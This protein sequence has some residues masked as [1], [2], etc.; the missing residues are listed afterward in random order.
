MELDLIKLIVAAVYLYL[1]ITLFMQF[2]FNNF[3]GNPSIKSE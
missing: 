1:P 3:E 2:F